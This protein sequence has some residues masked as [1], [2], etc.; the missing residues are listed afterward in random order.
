MTLVPCYA[1]AATTFTFLFVSYITPDI[2]TNYAQAICDHNN[3]IC[4]QGRIDHISR[5]TWGVASA[6]AAVFGLVA[7]LAFQTFVPKKREPTPGPTGATDETDEPDAGPE[8]EDQ[9]AEGTESDYSYESDSTATTE[10]ADPTPEPEE[11]PTVSLVDSVY[12]DTVPDDTEIN[13]P[14]QD[15]DSFM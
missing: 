12:K 14:A 10:P 11:K 9:F 5:G 6:L 7:G 4:T 13:Q 2:I 15:K 8:D 1:V 3:I